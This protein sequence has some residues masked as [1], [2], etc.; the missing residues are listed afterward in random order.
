MITKKII[1]AANSVARFIMPSTCL[2]CN[3]IIGGGHFCA[4][5]F[6]ELTFVSKPNCRICSWPFEYEVEEGCV[7]GSCLS[8][9]PR[10]DK[11]LYVLNYDEFS[12]KIIFS[13]KYLDK[14]YLSNFFAQL[15]KNAAD[16]V[17]DDID[18]LT[19]VCLHKSRIRKRKYN[20]SALLAKDLAKKVDKDLIYDLLI[21]T[22]KTKPQSSLTKAARKKNIVGAFKFNE[23][24]IS[25]VKGKNVAII[26]DVI[27]TGVTIDEYCKIL[28]RNGVNRIYVLTL[29]K[30][31][32]E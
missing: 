20:H 23:K 8:N 22:R 3:K 5:H 26:D 4:T 24:Y 9:K 31:I 2:I 28:R 15:I 30:A 27:T 6:N 32:L 10:Y 16:E 21:R 12:K 14:G 7:C 25:Q 13:F 29:A 19:P 18:I 1:S 11:A 17:M